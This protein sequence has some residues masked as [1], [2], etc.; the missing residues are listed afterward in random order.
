MAQN[1]KLEKVGENGAVIAGATINFADVF[2]RFSTIPDAGKKYPWM[3]TI[4]PYGNT[5]FNRIQIPLVVNELENLRSEFQDQYG[6]AVIDQTILFLG[7]AGVH[8]YIK[9]IGD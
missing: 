4:D 8:Q 5:I 2:N 9:F 3:A 7:K 6:N 1:I